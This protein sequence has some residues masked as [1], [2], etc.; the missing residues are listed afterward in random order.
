LASHSLSDRFDRIYELGRCASVRISSDVVSERTSDGCQL[1][2]CVRVSKLARR[3]LPCQGRGLPHLGKAPLVLAQ[4]SRSTRNC[5]WAY[6]ALPEARWDEPQGNPVSVT[7]A[8]LLPEPRG[9]KAEAGIKEVRGDE[10]LRI[11]RNLGG[12]GGSLR[13]TVCYQPSGQTVLRLVIDARG[14]LGGSL[15]PRLP[16]AGGRYLDPTAAAVIPMLLVGLKDFFKLPGSNQIR[17]A[18]GRQRLQKT[19]FAHGFSP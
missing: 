12:F 15:A 16:A 8:L 17:A 19:F 18:T 9:P 3:I 10:S 1:G 4:D 11:G 13:T 5:G 6:P 2:K 14:D 7:P